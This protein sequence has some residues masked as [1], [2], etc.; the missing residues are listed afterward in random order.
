MNMVHTP[1]GALLRAPL[2][3]TRAL[4]R[5]SALIAAV[6][7]A[8][9]AATVAVVSRLRPLYRA[10]A[11]VL[12]ETQ[13]IP[14]TFVAA[15]VQIMPEARL[16]R[17]KQQVLSRDRLWALI[18]EFGLYPEARARQTREEVLE[19]MRKDIGIALERGWSTSR[20]GAFRVSY[21]TYEPAIAAE[22]ANRIALFF[23]AE[24]LRQ[25]EAEAKGTSEFLE[26]QLAESKRNL[27]EQETRL[28]RYKAL[29]NGE[30]P[31]QEG[32]LLAMLGQSRVELQG[33]QD[34]LARAQ[35]NRLALESSLKL[36]EA[37]ARERREWIR[38]RALMTGRPPESPQA[39]APPSPLEQARAR[40]AE[41]QSRYHDTHPD[42]QRWQREVALLEQ[43]ERAAPPPPS[44]PQTAS[45]EPP[46]AP[47][48]PDAEGERIRE[49]RAQLALARQEIEAIEARR[50]RI[51]EEIAE[52]QLR[53]KN[54][55]IREQQLA[56][57]T[58]DYETSRVNYASL[59]NKKLAA[60]VAQNMEREEKAEKFVLLDRARTPEKPAW[61]RKR[62]FLAA[63]SA[64]S[65]LIAA[66]LALLLE[67][68]RN[69]VLGEWELPADTAILGR[70][71]KLRVRQA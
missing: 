67:W 44:A 19:F 58:R 54:V 12:V 14:E 45:A 69:A 4:W 56:A 40:L 15:T 16:D 10:D 20:P 55:P 11:L 65:L 24:N 7:L 17:L 43:A 23:V 30:L 9:T 71:P 49:L 37:A 47:E 6:L 57:I 18:E 1:G 41:L 70:I 53:L 46:P 36:A 3:I 34:A 64:A 13:K 59:L 48:T 5:R 32:T 2:S 63:G 39:G 21:Q 52:V 61:P 42:V 25:R 68:K 28:S 31:Q 51:L 33:A 38:L 22:A 8:G 35:Q 66:G 26:R 50:K 27:E 29:F 62:L 60:D